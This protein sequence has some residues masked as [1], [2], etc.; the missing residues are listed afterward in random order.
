MRIVISIDPGNQKC[1]LLLAD[2]VNSSVIHGKVTK[3]NHVIKLI[4]QWKNEY[5]I[6]LII[7]GNGTTSKYWQSQLNAMNIRPIKLVDETRTTLRARERYWELSPPIFPINLLPKT[8]ILPP[9][10]LDAVV[11]LILVEDLFNK[12]LEW[13]KPIEIKI[14]P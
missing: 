2:I 13:K 7:L 1:G 12:K 11:A 10:N 3:K 4:N 6:D 5:T 9:T 14:S 8:L